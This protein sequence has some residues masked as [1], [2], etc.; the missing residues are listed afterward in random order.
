MQDK[1]INNRNI[2]R[3][4]Q[5]VPNPAG[6]P[7]SLPKG[8]IMKYIAKNKN[9]GKYYVKNEGFSSSNSELA[10]ELNDVEV[11]VIEKL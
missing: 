2:N 7:D 3:E 10:T 4:S 8:K 9:T 11:S 1:T 6:R 5:I